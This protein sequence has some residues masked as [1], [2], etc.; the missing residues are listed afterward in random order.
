MKLAFDMTLRRPGCALIQAAFGGDT[1]ASSSFDVGTWL[2]F[3]TPEMRLY[4][5][6]EATLSKVAEAVN[7]EQATARS[8]D[9]EKG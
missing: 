4:E 8:S 2:V 5:L 9:P 1:S 7:R 3:P 6:D